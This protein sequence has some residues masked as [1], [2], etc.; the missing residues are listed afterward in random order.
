MAGDL[1]KILLIGRLTRDPEY[2]LV[3]QTSV[4]NFSLANNRVYI[5]N[6]EKKEE[7]HY[8]DCES[9]G[10][11]AET[12]KQF[13]K[14]GTRLAIEGRLKQERWDTPDGKVNSRIRIRVET[15]QF[16]GNTA[17][18]ED[19]KQ[20]Q[21]SQIDSGYHVQEEPAYSNISRMTEDEDDIF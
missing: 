3:N 21:G 15:F 13:A 11:Q 8:F 16:L 10:K 14:K 7:V 18:G 12:L 19:I 6:G 1:N 5:T 17:G 2:K 9:W 20:P 4:V